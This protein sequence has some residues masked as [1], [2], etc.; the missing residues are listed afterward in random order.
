MRRGEIGQ[1][2]QKNLLGRRGGIRVQAQNGRLDV[3][4]WVKLK[5]SG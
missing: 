1:S 3:Y 4:M 5:Y 2:E